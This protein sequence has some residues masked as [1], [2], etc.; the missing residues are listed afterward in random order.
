IADLDWI[1]KLPGKKVL[2]KGNHDLW[3]TGVKKLNSIYKSIF[4]LQ[5]SH[6]EAAGYAICGS[7]GWICPGN[8]YFSEEDKKIYEREMLR[9]QMSIDSI[10]NDSSEKLCFL[11]FPPTNGKLQKSGFTEIIENNGITKVC[12]GHLHGKETFKTGLQG[13][14]NGVS[15]NLIS[16]DFLKCKLKRIV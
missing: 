5:N 16:L 1:D 10:S 13:E 4:F 7:R 9:L 15:Y 2:I 8:E 3:W 6:F 11:H 14:R 12:Y